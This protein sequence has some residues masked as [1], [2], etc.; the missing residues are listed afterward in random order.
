MRAVA[1]WARMMRQTATVAPRSGQD[2]Y[3][4]PT[5]GAAVSYR[6]RL[7]GKRKL[8]LTAEGRQVVS[9]QTLYLMSDAAIDPE[10]QVTLSTGD[11]GSTERH[12][13]NP[14]ILGVGRYP[15]D[16]GGFHHT[17]LFLA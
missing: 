11:V 14:P 9:T 16:D 15:A 13:I 6:C 8:V 7:V 3:A 2:G 17:V 4:E 10:S 12:A 5:Y 1:G